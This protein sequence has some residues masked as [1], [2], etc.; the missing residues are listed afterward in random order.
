MICELKA[1]S[2]TL[3]EEQKIQVGLDSLLDSWETVM[4][5]MTHNKNI[6]TFDDLSCH[7]ELEAE[8]LEASKATKAAKSRSAYVANND[9]RMP[10]R[11]E[12]K[13]YAPRQD[14]GNGLVHT[15]T[16]NTK[17]NRGKHS[18]KEKN[19]KCFQCNKEGNF[20]QDFT[21]TRKV[22]LDFNSRKIYVFTHVMVHHS[23]PYWIVDSGSIE[24]VTRDR[25]VFVK[26]HRISKGSQGLYMRNGASIQMQDSGTY[27]LELYGGRTLLLH[28]V[29]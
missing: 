13:N 19:D 24:H 28:D 18:G 14:S 23:Y 5:S 10:R 1:A 16:K 25:V 22:L 8:C 3:T 12:H 29:L 26:Y 7:L 20:V 6:K 17:H 11:P 2:N 21:E 9:S 15:T 27:K 4:I